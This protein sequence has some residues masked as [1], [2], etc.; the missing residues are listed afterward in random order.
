MNWPSEDMQMTGKDEASSGDSQDYLLSG[1][2]IDSAR[3]TAARESVRSANLKPVVD[4]FAKNIK[5][6]T[7]LLTLPHHLAALL[8]ATFAAFGMLLRALD[9]TGNR[10]ALFEKEKLPG[11]L[12]NAEPTMTRLLEN[13]SQPEMSRHLDAQLEVVVRQYLTQD[14]VQS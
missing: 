13:L 7:D 3:V 14:N 9:E 5:D 1:I 11:A 8:P 12:G 4:A 10:D 6:V 2:A